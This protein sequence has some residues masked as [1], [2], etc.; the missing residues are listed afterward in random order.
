[1]RRVDRAAAEI[2]RRVAVDHRLPVDGH[3]AGDAGPDGARHLADRVGVIA[4]GE[5]R[6]DVPAVV[7]DQEDRHRVAGDALAKNHPQQAADIRQPRVAA[8]AAR[9]T[10]DREQ[11]F[12]A[13]VC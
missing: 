9:K 1:M 7:V 6:R 3:R 11:T 8:Q 2:E 5:P 4:G 12:G 10:R 13:L